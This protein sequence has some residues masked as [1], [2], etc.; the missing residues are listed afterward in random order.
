METEGKW[1]ERELKAGVDFISEGVSAVSDVLRT[2]KIRKE[3][4]SFCCQ[5]FWQHQG[6]MTLRRAVLGEG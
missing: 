5:G 3:K 4:S 6:L 2:Q 1:P